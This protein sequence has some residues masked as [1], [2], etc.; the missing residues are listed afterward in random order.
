LDAQRNGHA[1]RVQA[2]A[3]RV[4]E[5]TEA[6]IDDLTDDGDSGQGV[7]VVITATGCAPEA[8]D[9]DDIL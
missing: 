5:V 8:D 7:A 9:S 3:R 2:I 4:A 1:A 6:D